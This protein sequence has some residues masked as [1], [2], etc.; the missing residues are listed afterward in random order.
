[1]TT[2]STKLG[3]LLGSIAMLVFG[4]YVISYKVWDLAYCLLLIGYIIYYIRIKNTT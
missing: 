3:T 1:M 2:E 4:S